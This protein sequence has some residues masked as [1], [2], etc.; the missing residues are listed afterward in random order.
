MN[1]DQIFQKVI[2]GKELPTSEKLKNLVIHDSSLRN[3]TRFVE[4]SATSEF[5]SGRENFSST[6]TWSFNSLELS[7][8]DLAEICTEVAN[9]LN[10]RVQCN[11]YWTPA[12]SQG[13]PIHYDLHQTMIIQT[14]GSKKWS[15]WPSFRNS[16]NALTLLEDEKFNLPRWSEVIKPQN[17]VLT[18]GDCITLAPGVPHQAVATNLASLHFTFGAING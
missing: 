16:V 6:A 10:L 7:C 15:L 11:A 8:P 18:P 12:F 5:Q 17:K 1:I 9:I 14:E 13:L 4:T 3:R 2:H